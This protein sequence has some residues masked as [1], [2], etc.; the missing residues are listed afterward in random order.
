MPADT[1]PPVAP[2]GTWFRQPTRDPWAAW[3]RVECALDITPNRCMRSCRHLALPVGLSDRGESGLWR[4]RA[5]RQVPC[6]GAVSSTTAHRIHATHI[7]P[8]PAPSGLSISLFDKLFR[9]KRS[10]GRRTCRHLAPDLVASLH[11]D[12]GGL[13]PMAR[14]EERHVVPPVSSRG[15]RQAPVRSAPLRSAPVSLAPRMSACLRLA[16]ASLAFTSQAPRRSVVPGL[17]EADPPPSPAEGSC[18]DDFP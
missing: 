6:R 18:G 14:D 9:N 7:E 4:T 15:P 2:V 17:A 11:H 16:C 5:S 10:Q 1:S 8:K 3:A 12:P 13:S